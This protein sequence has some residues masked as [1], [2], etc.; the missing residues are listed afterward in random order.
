MTKNLNWVYA[1]ECRYN[2]VQY[3]TKLPKWLQE[4]RQN[5]NQMVDPKTTRAIGG[6]SFVG[7][8]ENIDR[9]ITT[10]HCI[11][12]EHLVEQIGIQKS[13]TQTGHVPPQAAIVYSFS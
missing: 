3:S 11:F 13:H 5:T 9:V 10:L 8:F 6:V 12:H 7:I 1:I 4:F 2:A